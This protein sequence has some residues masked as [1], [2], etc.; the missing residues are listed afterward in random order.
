[1]AYVFPPKFKGTPRIMGRSPSGF[2]E[3]GMLSPHGERRRGRYRGPCPWPGTMGNFRD[4]TRQHPAKSEDFRWRF[5][6]DL[7]L[8]SLRGSTWNFTI[9]MGGNRGN[10]GR[11]VKL[12]VSGTET[13]AIAVEHVMDKEIKQV[14]G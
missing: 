12:S 9:K 6:M 4:F 10:L 14:T 2:G 5:H 7:I 1:M 8:K 11:W 13:E 3:F